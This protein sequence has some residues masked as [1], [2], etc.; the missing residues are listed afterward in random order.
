MTAQLEFLKIIVLLWLN[1]ARCSRSAQCQQESGSAASGRGALR[2]IC[3]EGRVVDLDL[4]IS[5]IN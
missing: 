5:L 2:P 4:Q 1:Q 3:A